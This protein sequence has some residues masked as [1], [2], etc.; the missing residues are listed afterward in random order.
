[1]VVGLRAFSLLSIYHASYFL[2]TFVMTMSVSRARICFQP[3]MYKLP[4]DFRLIFEVW[5]FAKTRTQT[6]PSRSNRTLEARRPNISAQKVC[7]GLRSQMETTTVER[8]RIW[9]RLYHDI[10]APASVS[11]NSSDIYP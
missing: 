8:Q 5:I 11:G 1:M 10:K 9:T 3:H 4:G 7:S 6:S 2:S